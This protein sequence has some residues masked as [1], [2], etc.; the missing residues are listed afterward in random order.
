MIL[1][2]AGGSICSLR[3]RLSNAPP[4]TILV[5]L[6]RT[7]VA[8]QPVR[9]AILV[10]ERW[11]AETKRLTHLRPVVLDRPPGPVIARKVSGGDAELLGDERHRGRRQLAA[12]A[13]EPGLKLE[14]L[15]EQPEPEACRP[16][17]VGHQLPVSVNERP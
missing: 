15:Q 6:D 1:E 2:P 10:G 17:L 13:R 5:Q 12:V 16:G 9:P 7:N 3:Q 11:L 4:Y 14:E 8:S